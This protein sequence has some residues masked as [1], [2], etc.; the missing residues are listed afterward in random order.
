M[1]SKNSNEIKKSYEN[2][3]ELKEINKHKNENEITISK[4][5]NIKKLIELEFFPL[6]EA[7][8]KQDKIGEGYGGTI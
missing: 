6:I 8:E 1:I 5:K 7:V 4:E 3:N 2:E